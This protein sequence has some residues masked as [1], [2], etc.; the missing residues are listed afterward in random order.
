MAVATYATP[1]DVLADLVAGKIKQ[2]DAEKALQ[3]VRNRQEALAAQRKAG[4][5]EVRKAGEIADGVKL[6]IDSWGN[7]TFSGFERIGHG[8]GRMAAQLSGSALTFILSHAKPIVERLARAVGDGTER[9]ESYAKKTDKGGAKTGCRHYIGAVRI[10]EHDASF[11]EDVA[12]LCDTL[13]VE[14]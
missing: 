7:L 11:V 8:S 12:A 10:A 14:V 13:G 3:A 2:D 9:S 1:A 5:S 4:E 6:A